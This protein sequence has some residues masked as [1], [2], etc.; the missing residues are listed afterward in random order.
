MQHFLLTKDFIGEVQAGRERRL[1][2]HRNIGEGAL[3][4]L[5]RVGRWQHGDGT[6]LLEDD[7]ADTISALIRIGEQGKDGAFRCRHPF[8]Y[9]HGPGGIHDKEDQVGGPAHAH[10][11][12]QVGRLDG[13][14]DVLALVLAIALE[15]GRSPQRGIKGDIAGLLMRWTC[16]DVTAA[17]AVRARARAPSTLLAAETIDIAFD[18]TGDEI[19]TDLDLVPALPPAR[20]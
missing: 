13:E 17:L 14:S 1:A 16:L 19:F 20:V 8:G 5:N 7:Q 10:F 3:G 11:A 15:R 6:I 12:L 4:K 9:C 2:T 18:F